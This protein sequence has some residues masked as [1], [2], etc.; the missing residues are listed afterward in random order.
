MIHQ[1]VNNRTEIL[2]RATSHI[3]HLCN[4][5]NLVFA[6][7]I[8]LSRFNSNNFYQNR[9]KIKLFF[10]KKYKIFERWRRSPQTSITALL[11]CRYLATREV[12]AGQQTLQYLVDP[13]P[14][15][16]RV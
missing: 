11:H 1:L 3:A 4:W 8:S 9:P 14:V 6:L 16:F 10:P 15:W 13:F 2:A 7:L 5:Y 12:L